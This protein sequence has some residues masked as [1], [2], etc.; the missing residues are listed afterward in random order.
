M[1]LAGAVGTAASPAGTELPA[2]QQMPV[3]AGIRLIAAFLCH[4]GHSAKS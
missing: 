3:W 1:E 2:T 4:P